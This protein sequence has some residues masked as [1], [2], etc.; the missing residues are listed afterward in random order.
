VSGLVIGLLIAVTGGILLMGGKEKTAPKVKPAEGE[1]KPPKAEKT[2]A[3]RKA[4]RDKMMAAK[5]AKAAAKP[6]ESAA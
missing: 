4:W 1:A 2:P 5:A 3:E 6:K